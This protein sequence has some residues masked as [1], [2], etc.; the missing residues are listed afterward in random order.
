MLNS[1]G[2]YTVVVGGSNSTDAGAYPYRITMTVAAAPIPEVPVWAMLAF[3][4]AALG[5]VRRRRA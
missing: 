4:M 3:G 2:D 1:S 5:Y